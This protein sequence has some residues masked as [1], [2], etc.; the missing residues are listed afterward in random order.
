MH[1]IICIYSR[2]IEGIFFFKGQLILW[3]EIAIEKGMP[4]MGFE[5]GI[6]KLWGGGPDERECGCGPG[7]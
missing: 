2:L 3:R 4:E 6:R 1:N 7:L 5:G